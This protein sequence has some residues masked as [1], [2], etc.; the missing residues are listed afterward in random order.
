MIQKFM[1]DNNLMN[2][3]PS[4][5]LSEL[6]KSPN[7]YFFEK[8]INKQIELRRKLRKRFDNIINIDIKKIGCFEE[9]DDK[10]KHEKKIKKDEVNPLERSGKKEKVRNETLIE[11]KTAN[12][13]CD[14]FFSFTRFD[15]EESY[16]TEKK[17]EKD[18]KK[19]KVESRNV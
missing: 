8:Y 4:L 10:H 19:N 16:L 14:E 17:P 12:K 7:E 15:R 1:V 11:K 13:A 9:K 2:Q 5:I 6:S 3:S 18:I